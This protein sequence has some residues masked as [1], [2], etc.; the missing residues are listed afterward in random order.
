MD[1]WLIF[2]IAGVGIVVAILHTLLKQAGKDE[3]GQMVTLV[4]VLVV[5]TMVVDLMMK[6]FRSLTTFAR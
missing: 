4:G 5:L 2:K 6:L 1:V 3:Q